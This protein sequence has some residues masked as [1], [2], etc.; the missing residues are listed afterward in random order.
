MACTVVDY[1]PVFDDRL[2]VHNA[3]IVAIVRLGQIEQE[4]AVCLGQQLAVSHEES[5]KK[6]GGPRGRVPIAISLPL[7]ALY[8]QKVDTLRG[9]GLFVYRAANSHTL[10]GASACPGTDPSE[11]HSL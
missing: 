3:F 10:R 11:E 4:E 5:K 1:E 8:S 7:A 9:I 6:S 2:A